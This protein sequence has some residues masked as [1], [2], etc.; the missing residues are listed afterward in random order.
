VIGKVSGHEIRDN[1]QGLNVARTDVGDDVILAMLNVGVE[2][3]GNR[4]NDLR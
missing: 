3:Y 4:V 2:R 1:G